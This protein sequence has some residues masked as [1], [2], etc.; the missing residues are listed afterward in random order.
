[1]YWDVLTLRVFPSPATTC[2]STKTGANA[3][4]QLRGGRGKAKEREYEKTD[5]RRRNK[6]V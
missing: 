4:T 1:M 2:A 5:E 6:E 3:V